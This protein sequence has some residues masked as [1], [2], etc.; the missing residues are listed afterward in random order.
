MKDAADAIELTRR[1]VFLLKE[2]QLR[3][4]RQRQVI[5]EELRATDQHPSAD[6]LYSRVKQRLPRISLGTVYRNLE[7]LSELGEIQT[8]A[9]A[10]NLKRFDGM[11]QNHYHMRCLGC[12]RIFDAPLEL[13][14]ALERALQKKTDFR[15]LG[16]RLEFVGF[17]RDCQAR[18]G[19]DAPPDPSVA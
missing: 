17:C 18:R 11:A 5:L 10:G 7:I 8:I 3:M 6:A 2:R 16:H 15:I 19:E 12:D 14:D 1:P 9:S 13:V 4:T